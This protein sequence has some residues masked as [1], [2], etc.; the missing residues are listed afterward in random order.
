VRA[1]ALVGLL[2]GTMPS[3]ADETWCALPATSGRL[4]S[5][6]YTEGTALPAPVALGSTSWVTHEPEILWWGS[7]PGAVAG[8]WT[9]GRYY[10]WPRPRL[11]PPA[12]E[13][14]TQPPPLD[15]PF[16]TRVSVAKRSTIDV[17][18]RDAHL[19]VDDAHALLVATPTSLRLAV[20]RLVATRILEI[21]RIGELVP[22][23]A[24]AERPAA[25]ATLAQ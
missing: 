25:I 21:Q 12:P 13:V 8:P 1:W 6:G 11:P 7:L 2:L 14:A 9:G 19:T 17:D 15:G 3:A 24:P 10:H 16:V 5:G 4:W 23:F 18:L 20:L 22:L